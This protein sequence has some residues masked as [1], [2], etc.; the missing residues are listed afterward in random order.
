MSNAAT[1]RVSP[2]NVHGGCELEVDPDGHFSAI[3]KNETHN[4]SMSLDETSI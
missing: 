1:P 4:V 3:E 2:R